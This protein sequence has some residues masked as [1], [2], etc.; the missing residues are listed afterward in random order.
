PR[1]GATD[2]GP[3]ARRL[4]GTLAVE[5]TR[6]LRVQ[7]RFGRVRG[8][9]SGRSHAD[10]VL[11]VGA[12]SPRKEAKSS[13]KVLRGDP[14][15]RACLGR[16]QTLICQEGQK[17]EALLPGQPQEQLRVELRYPGLNLRRP[18]RR[19]KFQAIRP[20]RA[21]SEPAQTPERPFR[22]RPSGSRPCAGT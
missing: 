19:E 5:S 2:H 3:A 11:Q 22:E 16:K 4:L 6:R 12:S 13:A 17:Q 7:A 9:A 14:I 8:I 18:G 10:L 1:I 20:D 21:A 15:A